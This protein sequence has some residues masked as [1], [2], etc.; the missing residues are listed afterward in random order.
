MRGQASLMILALMVTPARD[1]Y[2]ILDN[3]LL[4]FSLDGWTDAA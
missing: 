2:T 1:V 3:A 4:F